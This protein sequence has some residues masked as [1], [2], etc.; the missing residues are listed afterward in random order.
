MNIN[1]LNANLDPIY[2]YDGIKQIKNIFLCDQIVGNFTIL[3]CFG[4]VKQ[5]Q[6]LLLTTI[7]Q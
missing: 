6:S 2:L 7:D 4:T 1:T 5:I 3:L